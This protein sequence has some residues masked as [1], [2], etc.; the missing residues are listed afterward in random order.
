MIIFNLKEKIRRQEA[1]PVLGCFLKMRSGIVIL[2]LSFLLVSCAPKLSDRALVETARERDVAVDADEL[3]G[4]PEREREFKTFWSEFR[5]DVIGDDWESLSSRVL[6]PL[7]TRAGLDHDP[8]IEVGEDEFRRVFSA[9]LNGEDP[10]HVGVSEGILI[11][12]LRNPN[13]YIVDDW[14]RIGDMQFRRTVDGWRLYWIFF[15]VAEMPKTD[16]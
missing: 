7:K 12:E 4:N 8:V 13:P 6:F 2:I 16:Q 3:P 5:R 1:I 11:R 9:F 15:D 14:V 10:S